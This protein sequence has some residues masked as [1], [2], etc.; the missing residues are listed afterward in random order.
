MWNL[1][2]NQS[3]YFS[4]ASAACWS[5]TYITNSMTAEERNISNGICGLN[6]HIDGEVIDNDYPIRVMEII[7]LHWALFTLAKLI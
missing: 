1:Y 4:R 3:Q 5:Q 6:D 7:L 2:L